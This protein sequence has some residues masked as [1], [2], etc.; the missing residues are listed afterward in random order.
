MMVYKVTKCR[1]R[2]A[3][4]VRCSVVHPKSSLVRAAHP[5]DGSVTPLFSGCSLV[6]VAHPT[7]GSVTQSIP[8]C[9]LVRVAHP[10]DGSVTQSFSRCSLVRTAH[11]TD[12]LSSPSF[13]G[14]ALVRAAHPTDGS[15]TQSF[16]RRVRR[17]HHSLNSNVIHHRSKQTGVTLIELI[18]TIAIAAVIIAALSGTVNVALQSEGEVRERNDL[19]QQARF[20]ML[21]MVTTV[22]DTR[23]LILP[24]AD[25]PATDWREHVREQTVPASTPEGSSTL[26]TAV[27]AVTLPANIDRDD[28]GWADANNDKDYMD[29]NNNGTQ[30]AGEF[31]RIDEDPPGDLTFD[32]QSG[33]I[34]IDDDGDGLVDELQTTPAPDGKMGPDGDDDDE[35]DV[36]NEDPWNGIDDDGDGVVDEDTKKDVSHDGLPGIGGVDDDFDGAIDES[37]DKN[38][39]DEDGTSNE[40]WLDPVVYYL[41]GSQLIERLPAFSDI[42]GDSVVTGADFTESVIAD[43][44]TLFRVERIP[45]GGDRTLRVDLKLV[46][47]N[48]DSGKTIELQA[49]VRV[50]SGS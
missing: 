4:H 50:G 30:D 8:R 13:S 49:Q 33:I 12:R 6:R 34:L 44:V 46:L 43:N 26:A 11:P 10:T 47:E 25:N 37:T 35:D 28:D 38:D 21:R 45:L 39:D 24:L 17:A 15:F 41:N 29:L 2:R 14:C 19:M 27:L 32:G 9:S 40:D 36:A 48:P 5:T 42:N 22:R 3:H 20:A 7:D 18:I 23:R 16:P 1:V 31:E